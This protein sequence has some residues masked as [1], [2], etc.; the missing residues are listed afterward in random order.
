MPIYRGATEGEALH[1]ALDG[2]RLGRSLLE[3]HRIRI[4]DLGAKEIGDEEGP[5]FRRGLRYSRLCM[6]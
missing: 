3:E 5:S 1:V 2:M 4:F 6:L